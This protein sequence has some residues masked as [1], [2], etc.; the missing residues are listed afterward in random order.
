MAS[1]N[2]LAECP[3]CGSQLTTEHMRA[4]KDGVAF[5]NRWHHRCSDCKN[6]IIETEGEGW[7]YCK[8]P[9]LTSKQ[10]A[11]RKAKAEKLA[12][13]VATGRAK[14]GAASR[15]AKTG[16]GQPGRQAS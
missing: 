8:S 4:S 2:P 10:K 6:R 12:A 16:P 15:K 3:E 14:V 11:A 13:K 1:E 7:H 9:P 5:F